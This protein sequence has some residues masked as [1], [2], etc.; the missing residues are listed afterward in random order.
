MS[1]PLF[2]SDSYKVHHPALYHPSTSSMLEYIEARGCA[3]DP[4]ISELAFIGMQYITKRH[5][6]TRLTHAH[7]DEAKR[8]LK[9]HFLGR[10]LFYEAGWR[11]IVDEFDGWLPL[12]VR[13]VREGTIVPLS[14]AMVIIKE[15]H[16]DFAWLVPQY[17][18]VFLRIWSPISVASGSLEALKIN[19]EF[20]EKTTDLTEEER[21]QTALIM[22]H[23][24]GCRGVNVDEQAR[25][26]GAAHL[27][28]S[29]G[30]D[31]LPALEMLDEYYGCEMAG[32]SVSATEHSVMTQEGEEGELNV[33]NRVLDINLQ[34]GAVFSVV[35]D[36][37]DPYRFAREYIGTINRDRIMASG[38]TLVARPD[39]GHPP[40]VVPELLE[41]FWEC[42]GGTINSKGMR[43]LHPCIKVLQGDGITLKSRREIHE[44]V[45][46]AGF[47]AQNILFGS[48]G[49]R[50]NG[51]SRDSFKFASKVCST[52]INGV[53]RDVYKDPITDSGKRS[54]RGRLMLVRDEADNFRT[55]T[56]A[57]YAQHASTWED[58]MV[59]Y[60]RNGQILHEETFDQIRERAWSQI[61]RK[62]L[63]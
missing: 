30:T 10:D 36:S 20:L 52:T 34:P 53:E 63:A 5:F 8:K 29:V 42:F 4:Y 46:T 54:K 38:A 17:E 24:F 19:L 15:T 13:A 47:A 44:A 14:Q 45:M 16:P 60:Y 27:L 48:G 28:F 11:R 23:D 25:V 37:Y 21:F 2:L 41:I 61:R 57:E 6:T 55:V 40:I 35:I 18:A 49:D 58:Q 62:V 50:L 59:T 39:S 22:D 1:N 31:T 56:E 32:F 33:F 12:E 51:W 3:T 43:V 7:I 9:K 26:D